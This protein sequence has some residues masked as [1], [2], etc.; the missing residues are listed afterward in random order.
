MPNLTEIKIQNNTLS[1]KQLSY[2]KWMTTLAIIGIPVLAQILGAMMLFSKVKPFLMSTAAL[3][4]FGVACLIVLLAGLYVCSNRLH[5]RFL[6]FNRGLDE[7]E[8]LIQTQAKAFAYQTV[9]FVILVLF[10]LVSLI[11]VVG[12]L[13]FT[14]FINIDLGKTLSFDIFEISILVVAVFYIIMFLPTLHMV[15]NIKP[16]STED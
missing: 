7:W 13:G 4:L 14:D 6:G 11:G 10:A 2:L 16:L 15:W 8:R 1:P 5:L 9:F 3:S 12:V